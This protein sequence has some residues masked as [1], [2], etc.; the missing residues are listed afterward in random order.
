MLFDFLA[1]KNDIYFWR[2]RENMVGLSSRTLLWRA[3]S[4]FV[5][6]LYLV[7]ENTSLLVVIPSAIGTLIEVLYIIQVF[8]NSVTVQFKKWIT[9]CSLGMES[10]QS[11]QDNMRMAQWNSTTHF[12]SFNESRRSENWRVRFI[13][14]EIFVVRALSSLFGWCN[15]F[16]CLH[17]SSKV[18]PLS[19][20]STRITQLKAYSLIYS[21]WQT[22]GILGDCK[23]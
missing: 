9:T 4:Q 19:H 22:A 1:F 7:D 20:K 15:L 14:Y 21:F 18:N 23:A 10:N 12:W 17:F 16:S 2:D 3:F 11:I 13:E 5:I 8:C 6:F